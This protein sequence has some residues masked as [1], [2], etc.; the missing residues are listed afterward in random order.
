MPPAREGGD[1]GEEKLDELEPPGAE[2]SMPEE[3]DNASEEAVCTV[4]PFLLLPRVREQSLTARL[5]T[6]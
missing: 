3:M 2:E 4:S 6:N 1:G 5:D